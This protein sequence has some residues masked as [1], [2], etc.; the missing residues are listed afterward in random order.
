MAPPPAHTA[1]IKPAIFALLAIN[2]GIYTVAGRFSQGLDALAWFALLALFEIETRYPLWTRITRNAAVLDLLRLMATASVVIA[3]LSFIHEGEWLDATN[4]WLWIGVLAV[5]ELEVRAPSW[6]NRYRKTATT[7]SL[8]LY[9]ALAVVAL[10]WLAQ[11]AWFDGYDALLW[12]AAFGLIEMDL[13]RLAAQ[14]G[15][16]SGKIR[17]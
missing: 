14:T 11:G 6:I 13:L 16:A 1:L 17:N 15:P 10:A 4:S 5:L 8:A 3:A 9:G 12:I 7:V 2:A